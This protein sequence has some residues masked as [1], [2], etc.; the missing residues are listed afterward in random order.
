MAV[1]RVPKIDH[2]TVVGRIWCYGEDYQR[3]VY[4]AH[5]YRDTK[6]EWYTEV[7][8]PGY[9]GN[10]AMTLRLQALGKLLRYAYYCGANTVLF[11]DL[12]RIKKRKFNSSR[13]GNRKISRFPKKKLLEHGILMAWK[14]GFRVYLVN[15]NRTSKLAEKFKNSFGLDIHTTSAYTLTLRFLNQ[16]TFRKLSKK[17]LQRTLLNN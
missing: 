17:K 1:I 10:K 4:L 11:E 7:N 6:T 2:V 12:D 13:N 14:Y 9:P 15:P 8:S 5:K 16:E 3:L